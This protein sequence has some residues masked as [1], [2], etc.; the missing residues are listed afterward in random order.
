MESHE[1]VRRHSEATQELL[2]LAGEIMR[3]DIKNQNEIRDCMLRAHKEAE[4]VIKVM[5]PHWD[6]DA[7]TP[8]FIER[9]NREILPNERLAAAKA[10]FIGADDET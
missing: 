7:I 8:E 6:P 1:W 5:V 3:T 10:G 9:L 4:G 2:Y